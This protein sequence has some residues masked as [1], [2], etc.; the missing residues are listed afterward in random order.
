MKKVLSKQEKAKE[1]LKRIKR[2]KYQQKRRA[3]LAIETRRF[4]TLAPKITIDARPMTAT[5]KTALAR[6]ADNMVDRSPTPLEAAKDQARA[7]GHNVGF[8][9]AREQA[10]RDHA[11]LKDEALKCLADLHDEFADVSKVTA[12]ALRYLTQ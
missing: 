9:S 12:K 3:R 2:N 8:K 10:V 5:V 1:D 11:E 6:E 7:E 4:K